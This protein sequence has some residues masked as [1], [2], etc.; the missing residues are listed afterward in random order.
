MPHND[1]PTLSGYLKEIQETRKFEIEG[2]RVA[3]NIMHFLSPL[4]MIVC[5]GVNEGVTWGY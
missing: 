2:K 3:I 4:Y 1:H 5:L